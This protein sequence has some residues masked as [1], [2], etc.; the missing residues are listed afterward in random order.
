MAERGERLAHTTRPKPVRIAV[1]AALAS[2]RRTSSTSLAYSSRFAYL[3]VVVGD[4]NCFWLFFAFAEK[5]REVGGRTYV[6]GILPPFSFN[7]T[8]VPSLNE[9]V[10]FSKMMFVKFSSVI[11]LVSASRRPSRNW[12]QK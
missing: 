2:R 10:K 4:V 11:P 1:N 9:V 8:C 6:T 3:L 5:E 7:S 12:Q